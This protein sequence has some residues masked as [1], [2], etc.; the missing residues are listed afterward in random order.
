MS[1]R[2]IIYFYNDVKDRW[3]YYVRDSNKPTLYSITSTDK[4][5]EAKKFIWRSHAENTLLRVCEEL[6]V[7]GEIITFKNEKEYFRALLGG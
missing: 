4:I 2:F 3:V 1:E 7:P 5:Q 6:R